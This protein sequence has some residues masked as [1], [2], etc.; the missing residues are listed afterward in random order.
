MPYLFVCA[1]GPVQDFIATARRSRDLWYGSWMLSELSKAAARCL[2]ADYGKDNLVF[3]A[4]DG[5]GELE[6]DTP[7]NVA[8][9][10][11]AV[12]TDPPEVVGPKVEGAVHERLTTLREDAFRA[13]RA[14]FEKGGFDWVLAERQIAGLPEIYWVGIEYVADNGYAQARWL[15]EHLLAARKTTRDFGQAVGHGVPKSSLDG[16]RESVIPEAGYP[17]RGENEDQ[18]AL[19][20]ARLYEQYGARG[21]ERLSGVDVLKRLGKRGAVQERK[22]KSTSHMAA[23][24]FRAFVHR[25]KGPGTADNLIDEIKT[26]LRDEKIPVSG[27]DDSLLYES[28]LRDVVGDDAKLTSLRGKLADI[29]KKYAGQ[30]QP[31]SYYVLLAADGDHMGAAIDA[32]TKVADHR[33]LSHALSRFAADAETIV[34]KH[35]G[36]PV[37]SGG[38]D[39]LAY[40]PVH[41]A[42]DCAH[43]LAKAFKGDM[44]RFSPPGGAAPTLSVGL[45]VAHHL[46]PLA[47]ALELARDAERTA[48]NAGRDALAVILSKRSGADR[49]VVGQWELFL[50]RLEKMIEFMRNGAISK[51]AAY[52]LLELDRVLGGPKGLPP[53]ALAGETQRILER[54]RESGGARQADREAVRCIRDWLQQVRLDELARELIVAAFFVG[55]V[56]LALGEIR[57]ETV[58]A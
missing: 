43:E 12:V 29:R 31:G 21:G 56:D 58:N 9:R 20:I 47:D 6:P 53:E 39:V 22:F 41:T 30:A 1:L 8:N 46:E 25:T 5:L 17:R 11:V 23:A 37:Y 19:K 10:V 4:P 54:K 33:S 18:R 16:A 55:S 34:A 27:E 28:R 44:M 24:P 35:Q 26:L 7:L 45:V 48:K 49:E 2:A 14:A 15:A 36:V 32:Q 40:L 13:V 51:G 42:L 52:E 38:D 50:P 57:K 3:P